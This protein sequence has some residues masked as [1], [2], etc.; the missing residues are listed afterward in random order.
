MNGQCVYELL[1]THLSNPSKRINVTKETLL[2]TF[3]QSHKA[4]E[5]IYDLDF[6]LYE[7]C[8]ELTLEDGVTTD[9]IKYLCMKRK[10]S[11]YAFDGKQNCF[12]KLVFSKNSNYRPIAYYSI[13][14]HVFNYR[15]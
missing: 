13:D 4:N 6:G 1:S 15:H 2:E 9:M 8:K 11:L 14:G 10:I 7:P 3:Q 12:E 5:G